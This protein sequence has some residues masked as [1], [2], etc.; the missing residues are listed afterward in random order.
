MPCSNNLKQLGVALHKHLDVT[1]VF[2]TNSVMQKPGPGVYYH[3]TNAGR[4]NYRYGRLNYVVALLPY[5]DQTALYD[6]CLIS[7][8]SVAGPEFPAEPNEPETVETCPWFKQI[9]ELRCPS[10]KGGGGGNNATNEQ[11]GRNNYMVSTGDWPDA[12]V[13]RV[14]STDEGVEGYI[15]NPR[16]AFPMKTTIRSSKPIVEAKS[17]RDISDG[18]SNTVAVAEKCLGLIIAHSVVAAEHLDIK[19]AVAV[20]QTD[21]V[22][23]S[24]GD[25]TVSP[26]TAGS[27]DRCLD[28]TVSDGKELLV[29]GVGE[30]GGVRWADGIAA[31]SSFSTILPPNS[32]SC[33]TSIGEPLD[34]VLSAASSEHT[35]GVNCLRFDG[36]VYFFSNTIACGNLH[37]F[38]VSSGPSPYGIWGALGS[39]NGGES[40]SP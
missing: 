32:P 31:Y 37:A 21:A 23:G 10:D 30:T 25:I 12:H 2:P 36:S 40:V 7:P 8:T 11:C 22:A 14:R 27:P 29:P 19:R 3:S 26:T 20:A 34:R 16:G 17:M 4:E 33:T 6:A 24:P 5:M 1:G 18:A 38:A 39:I 35:G 9:P 13:Y 15:E 28:T